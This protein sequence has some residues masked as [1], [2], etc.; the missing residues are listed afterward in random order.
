MCSS[1]YIRHP[2]SVLKLLMTFLRFH[3]D[4]FINESR[5]LVLLLASMILHTRMAR[6]LGWAWPYWTYGG[7]CK[8]MHCIMC[9]PWFSTFGSFCAILSVNCDASRGQCFAALDLWWHPF[10][11]LTRQNQC[12]ALKALATVDGL[13]YSTL[14][15]EWAPLWS[16]SSTHQNPVFLWHGIFHDCV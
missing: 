1:F 13:L 6:E 5:L 3:N 11:L 10:F 15:W 2:N 9:V 4:S 14:M 8:M 12:W 7:N 16:Y